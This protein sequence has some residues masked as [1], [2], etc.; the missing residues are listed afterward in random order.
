M[1][2]DNREDIL[3]ITPLWKGERFPDGR[4]KVPDDILQRMRNITLEEAWGIGT[5]AIIS[6]IGALAYQGKEYSI[7]GGEIGPFAQ[8]LYDDLSGIQWGLKAYSMGWT[9]P[10]DPPAPA[11][12]G[13]TK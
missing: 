4:P 10:I 1:K 12:S 5:A 3:Q 7:H 8:K 11:A 6:P 9:F 13:S 2:F